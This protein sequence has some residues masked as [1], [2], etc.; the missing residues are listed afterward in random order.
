MRLIHVPKRGR[1][2][3]QALA[4]F[5]L[6]FPMF[7]LLLFSII[8]FGLYIF[9]NQQLA[10]AAREGARYAAVHSS[11]AQRPTVSRL[12]PI[13]PLRPGSYARADAPEAGW[14]DMTAAARS[15][16]W[17]MAPNQVS[18][19]A[20]WS[21]YVDAA[22]N[23][24]A[25][26]TAANTFTDCTMNGVNPRTNPS[27]LACPAPATVPS[28]FNPAKADGD[29]KASDIAAAVGNNQHY[30]TTVT[31]YTCFVWNPPMAGFVFIPNQIMI[32]AVI[33]EA[34]QRQQ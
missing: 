26:P 15:K 5:A 10:N 20:C 13:G 25:L 21:G 23:Y 27:S 18:L 31:V 7:L 29:D 6:V 3:G 19:T 11:T 2:R 9:Y 33:T 12:D 14:P 17:G 1:G 34:L 16:I 24:D 8:S 28:A 22:G 4:E 30:P 32:R